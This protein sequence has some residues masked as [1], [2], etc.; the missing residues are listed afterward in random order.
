MKKIIMK[1][2]F[3]LN[4]LFILH[5]KG[6][7]FDIDNS[8]GAFNPLIYILIVGEAITAF[9]LIIKH[10]FTHFPKKKI[11]FISIKLDSVLYD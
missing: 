8:N 10:I 6:K 3:L 7:S 1:I 2:L 5:L 4:F 9:L 11:E